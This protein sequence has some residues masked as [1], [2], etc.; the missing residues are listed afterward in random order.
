MVPRFFMLRKQ[1][2]YMNVWEGGTMNIEQLVNRVRFRP[3]MFTGSFS[4]EP[5]VHF[6]NGFLYNNLMSDRADDIDIAFKNQFH[7]WVRIQLE[8]KYKIKL[9][10]NRDYLT[11]I[12]EVYQDLEQGLKVFFELCDEFFIEM[13]KEEHRI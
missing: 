1:E 5:M 4:L 9:E 8:K 3:P 10:K 6:I 7:D 2:I 13:H 12:S 11:Y